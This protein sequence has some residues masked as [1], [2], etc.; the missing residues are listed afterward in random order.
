MDNF[1]VPPQPLADGASGRLIDLPRERAGW[2]WM[3]FFV[4]R[5]AAG[6]KLE[7]G[8]ATEETALV[9]LGGRC[10]AAWGKSSTTKD[11]KEHE[12]GQAR[13]M[14]ERENVFDGLPYALYLPAGGFAAFEAIT[15]CEIA[16]CRVP[17]TA[18]HEPRL[19]T[20]DDVQVSL[21][22]GGN[23]SRQI[24][25]LMPPAFPA[26]RIIAVEVYTPG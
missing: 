25:D 18:Q 8:S 6:A 15:A 26:D 10:R 14:G 19:I 20:P 16:E 4:H 24:V 17:S 11:T 5:L 2:E 22:G 3:S 13:D 1:L 9:L 21:C 7:V 12:G 23:A